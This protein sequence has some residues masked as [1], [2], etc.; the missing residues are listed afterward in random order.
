MNACKAGR[1]ITPIAEAGAR[2]SIHLLFRMFKAIELPVPALYGMPVITCPIKI[3]GPQ[4]NIKL[5]CDR[6]L[7]AS[8]HKNIA[9]GPVLAVLKG[10]LVVADA[11]DP[12][13]QKAPP[14]ANKRGGRQTI[15]PPTPPPPPPKPGPIDISHILGTSDLGAIDEEMV[16]VS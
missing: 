2:L 3:P 16:D 11:M 6:H 12:E 4:C 7:L 1:D 9:V 8:A 10:I 14:P 13:N 5:S 15:I